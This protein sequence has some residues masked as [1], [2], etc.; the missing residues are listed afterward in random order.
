MR[1]ACSGRKQDRTSSE[2]SSRSLAL[3]W[4]SPVMSEA[5]TPRGPNWNFPVRRKKT[6]PPRS[7]VRSMNVIPRPV[8]NCLRNAATGS[9]GRA[10]ARACA[11]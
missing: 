10:V 5:V 3:T 1:M 9:A 8:M 4:N 7:E 11:G 2:N 6:S